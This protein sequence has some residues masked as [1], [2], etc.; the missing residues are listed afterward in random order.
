MG[1]DAMAD[2]MLE[3]S[4]SKDADVN[5]DR[6]RVDTR[7][8]YLAKLAPKR[9][10]NSKTVDLNMNHRSVDELTDAELARIATGGSAGTA[11]EA[12]GAGKPD[13]VH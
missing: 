8:W 1:L 4:D 6:L 7:K 13:S 12:S 3:I 10:G 2:E 11:E 9:F 5:R